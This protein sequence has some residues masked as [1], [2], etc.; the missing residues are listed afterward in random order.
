MAIDEFLADAIKADMIEKFKDRYDL[1]LLED[2]R[3]GLEA[4]PRSSWR[5]VLSQKIRAQGEELRAE[6]E[7]AVRE[8]LPDDGE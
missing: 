8:Y 7:A 6:I 1:D 2:V 4:K 5:D 3:E